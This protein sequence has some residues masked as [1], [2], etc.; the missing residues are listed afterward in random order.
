MGTIYCILCLQWTYHCMFV[1]LKLKE[2]KQKVLKHSIARSWDLQFLSN[3]QTSVCTELCRCGRGITAHSGHCEQAALGTHKTALPIYF[4]GQTE[5]RHLPTSWLPTRREAWRLL[6]S[7]VPISTGRREIWFW[8]RSRILIAWNS[9][10][11][12][13]MIWIRVLFMCHS[14]RCVCSFN[15]SGNS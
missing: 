7:N 6:L 8:G 4:R 15:S 13:G 14:L 5:Q 12:V 10:I 2:I 1:P 9:S 3:W 11:Y